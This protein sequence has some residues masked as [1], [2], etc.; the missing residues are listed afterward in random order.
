MSS[1]SLSAAK[2]EQRAML[3]FLVHENVVLEDIHKCLKNVYSESVM[4]IQHVQKWVSE[5]YEGWY[6]W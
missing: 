2:I 5:F 3:Y 6:V 4:S 1:T